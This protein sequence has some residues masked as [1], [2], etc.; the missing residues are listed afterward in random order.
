MC[1]LAVLQPEWDSG[2]LAGFAFDVY[3]AMPSSLGL[4]TVFRDD[5]SFSYDIYRAV[6]PEYEDVFSFYDTQ[7]QD[8]VFFHIIHGRLATTGDVIEEHAHP[9]EIDCPECN[10]DYVLHNGVLGRW[11]MDRREHEDDGH[12]YN[13]EV[14]SEVIAHDHSIVPDDFDTPAMEKYSHEPAYILL[15]GERIF[16]SSPGRTYR[17]TDDPMLARPRRE[18]APGHRRDDYGY[19]IIDA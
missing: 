5:G 9:L 1:E 18:F 15:G 3:S 10:I 19:L 4:V 16:M 2:E 6:E 8:E 13:T 7:D 17:L 11:Q 12:E 14:D